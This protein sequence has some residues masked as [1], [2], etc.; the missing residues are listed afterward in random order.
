MKHD[1]DSARLRDGVPPDLKVSAFE[2]E[3]GSIGGG[4]DPD[5]LSRGV[6]DRV[7]R[8]GQR[9]RVG[10]EHGCNGSAGNG[11]ALDHSAVGG[12]LVVDV[13][14]R[15]AIRFFP[16]DRVA[17]DLHVVSRDHDLVARTDRQA[18]SARIDG[19]VLDLGTV[20]HCV[21]E[22]P[23]GVAGRGAVTGDGEAVHHGAIGINAEGWESCSSKGAAAAIEGYGGGWLGDQLQAVRSE[24]ERC[25]LNVR[26]ALHVDAAARFRVVDSGLDAATRRRHVLRVLANDRETSGSVAPAVVH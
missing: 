1:V 12:S 3:Y 10:G 4:C 2:A 9:R 17:Y 13:Q 16:S 11:V 26:T 21:D 25:R 6:R 20:A 8:Y 15:Q 18:L 7:V 19:E 5:A 23:V 22:R 24:S 14:G